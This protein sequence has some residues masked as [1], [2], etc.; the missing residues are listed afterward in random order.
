MAIKDG[1][2]IDVVL[3]EAEFSANLRA[4]HP[5]RPGGNGTSES[6]DSDTAAITKLDVPP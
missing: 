4:Q 3:Q 6:F 1:F 2:L 5:W